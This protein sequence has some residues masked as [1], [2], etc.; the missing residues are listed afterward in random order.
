MQTATR[1][2]VNYYTPR[3]YPP[4]AEVDPRFSHAHYLIRAKVFNVKLFGA[5]FHC[6]DTAGN[7]LFYTRQKAFKL[8]E[9]IRLYTGEDMRT[10]LLT[11]Q[12]RQILD[13]SAAYDVVDA[14][15]GAK[16]GAL[17][18]RGWKSM[19]RDEWLVMDSEDREMG[20]IRED[21]AGLA[22]VR[23]LI[24]LAA[25]FIP[26]RFVAEVGGQT[27]ATFQQNANPFGR[28]LLVDFSHDRDKRLD[29]RLGL[30]AAILLAAIE[31]R[32]Q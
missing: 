2:T 4:P 9:D 6:Y 25:V 26:Q 15:S 16:V 12:A 24:G 14:Q 8:R 22:V 31:G 19:L 10:E 1:P 23:R 17:R 5:V 28:K 29:R 30:G 3:P 32:Q 18:R 11:I 7:L 21:D 27:A 20:V 13:F